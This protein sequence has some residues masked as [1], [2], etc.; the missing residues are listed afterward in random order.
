MDWKKCKSCSKNKTNIFSI[1]WGLVNKCGVVNKDKN[2]ILLEI[3]MNEIKF[4]YHVFDIK[5]TLEVVI[6]SKGIWKGSL[7]FSSI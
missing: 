2:Y 1:V 4:V 7:K 3:I 6:C 5:I